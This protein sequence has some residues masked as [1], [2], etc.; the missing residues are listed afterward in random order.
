MKGYIKCKRGILENLEGLKSFKD[1]NKE[2]ENFFTP[3]A[4]KAA[5]VHDILCVLEGPGLAKILSSLRA[6]KIPKPYYDYKDVIRKQIT[7]VMGLNTKDM[8]FFIDN[9]I[10]VKF[11]AS[12]DTPKE[13]DRRACGLDKDTLEKYKQEFFKGTKHKEIALKY[14]AYFVKDIISFKKIN[15]LQ[16]KKAFIPI[17]VNLLEIIVLEHTDF[18]DTKYIRGFSYYLLREIFDDLMLHVAEDIFF[19]FANQEKKAIEFL[20]YFSVHERIDENGVRYK[21]NPILD[22]S[23]HAWNMTTIRSTMLQHK[24]AKQAFYDKKNVLIATKEKLEKH[25]AIKEELER[26]KEAKDM[27]FEELKKKIEGIHSTLQKL[28]ENDSED[29]RFKE[30]GEERTYKRKPLIKRMFKKEDD[31]LSQRQ[32]LKQI[33]S[34]LEKR[35]SNKQKDIDIWEKKYIEYEVELTTIEQ[36]GHPVDKKYESMKIALAKALT[37]H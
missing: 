19:G 28:R 21:A 27:D 16:F 2:V 3:K 17:F 31:Y 29:V 35:I 12:V 15:P 25:Y 32:V 30:D 23:S 14:I 37:R 4:I 20:S 8:V 18:E 5:S 34:D 13:G 7:K 9:T 24:K 6:C 33:T 26:Q 10:Y 1:V 11:F 22:E 36:K